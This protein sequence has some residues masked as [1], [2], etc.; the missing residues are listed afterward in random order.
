MYL[1]SCNTAL[2]SFYL[3]QFY[4][5]LTVS[6]HLRHI[7]RILT[8][9]DFGSY[10]SV[11]ISLVNVFLRNHLQ[12]NCRLFLYHIIK[13]Y[14]SHLPY[15]FIHMNSLSPSTFTIFPQV[16]TISFNLH[17]N[18]HMLKMV[19]F[20]SFLLDCMEFESRNLGALVIAQ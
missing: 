2:N 17:D 11:Y 1:P 14:K 18:I 13:W 6:E 9:A 12:S 15:A 3:T 5:A 20:S 8:L 4:T 7:L 16:L 10:L 19:K